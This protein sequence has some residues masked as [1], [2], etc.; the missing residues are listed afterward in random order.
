MYIYVRKNTHVKIQRILD[1]GMKL[2]VLGTVLDIRRAVLGR[3]RDLQTSWLVN[4]TC[5][6]S[7]DWGFVL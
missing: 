7:G 6:R 5:W 1:F 4:L 3:L 2:V